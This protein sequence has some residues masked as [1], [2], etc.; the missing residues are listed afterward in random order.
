MSRRTLNVYVLTTLIFFVYAWAW[1]GFTLSIS[2]LIMFSIVILLTSTLFAICSSLLFLFNLIRFRLLAVS[3]RS[4]IETHSSPNYKVPL[5]WWFI[6]GICF[7]FSRV[8][9]YYFP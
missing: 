6:F 7:L 2:A 8:V 1:V 3:S 4:K 9:S 5:F